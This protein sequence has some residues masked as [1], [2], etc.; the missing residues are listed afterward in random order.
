MK[1]KGA[2]K[3]VISKHDHVMAADPLVIRI[4]LKMTWLQ[5]DV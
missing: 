5:I 3:S 4:I 1:V 2:L